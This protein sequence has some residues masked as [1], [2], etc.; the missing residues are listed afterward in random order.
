MQ[1]LEA[2]EQA[3]AASQQLCERESAEKEKVEIALRNEIIQLQKK[4]ETKVIILLQLSL[5]DTNILLEL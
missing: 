3:H 1:N 5:D 2:A 4:L